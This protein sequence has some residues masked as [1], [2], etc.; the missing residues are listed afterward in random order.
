[1]GLREGKWDAVSL[2]ILLYFIV[3]P[4][5]KLVSHDSFDKNINVKI[6]TLVF[7]SEIIF[8]ILL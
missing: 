3:S 5:D 2:N 1:M 8:Q 6:Q 4:S 7:L